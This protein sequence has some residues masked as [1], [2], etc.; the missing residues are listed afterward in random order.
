M[1]RPSRKYRPFNV[2]GSI[3][4]DLHR[5][6]RRLMHIADRLAFSSFL[7]FCSKKLTTYFIA[8]ASFS[9]CTIRPVGR[10]VGRSLDRCS[11]IMLESHPADSSS[12]A[13]FG[14][15][16]GRF[17]CCKLMKA[18]VCLHER[19][20]NHFLQLSESLLLLECARWRRTH[21][22]SKVLS[23]AAALCTLPLN[24]LARIG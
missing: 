19:S 22:D 17:P 20:E 1:N 3:S 11:S 9:L 15:I 5:L 13:A 7:I 10:S 12:S 14:R 18:A 21:L 2:S 23:T 8:L 16:L 6:R 4:C 24:L